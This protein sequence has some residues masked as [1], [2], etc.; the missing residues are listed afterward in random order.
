MVSTGDTL[1]IRLRPAPHDE[2]VG[3]RHMIVV[4]GIEWLRLP[5]NQLQATLLYNDPLG[6]NERA[7]NFDEIEGFFE[8]ALVISRS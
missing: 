5:N 7:V 8:Q 3:I 6:A 1:L 2:A 4:R